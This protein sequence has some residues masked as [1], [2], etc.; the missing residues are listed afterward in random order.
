MRIFI[1]CRCPPTD[2]F[3]V[4]KSIAMGPHCGWPSEW[5]VLP[6]ID[7]E[8]A[9]ERL[10]WGDKAGAL[11]QIPAQLAASFPELLLTSYIRAQQADSTSP[12]THANQK[13]SVAVLVCLVFDSTRAAATTTS[14]HKEGNHC[15][16]AFGN[17]SF[18]YELIMMMLNQS[19]K[20]T[21][22][23]SYEE[24]LPLSV[25][26]ETP[27]WLHIRIQT[28]VGCPS[29]SKKHLS[30]TSQGWPSTRLDGD[31]CKPKNSFAPVI[32]YGC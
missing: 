30:G 27:R 14:L 24:K 19:V 23:S 26:P 5:E 3:N 9:L 16:C 18:R 25:R 12:C 29:L 10:Q 4:Q 22:L 11:I 2:L 1:Q 28:S 31:I 17:T 7:N 20:V 8:Y 21:Q 15:I 32:D 6:C 13:I